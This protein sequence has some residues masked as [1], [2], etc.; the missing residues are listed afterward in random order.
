MLNPS[1]GEALPADYPAQDYGRMFDHTQAAGVG[2][3]GIR[4]LA[5][6]A[7]SGTAERHPIASP[8]PDPIGSAIATTPTCTR[9]AAD[10]A[11]AAGSCGQP[12]RG[13]DTF[14]DQHKAMGTILVGMATPEQF[15][16]SLAAVNK[17]PLSRGS[18]NSLA[19]VQRG[20]AGE[21]RE[22]FTASTPARRAGPAA[23]GRGVRVCQRR[24]RPIG[25]FSISGTT[26]SAT[27]T[28]PGSARI[29]G[30]LRVEARP[31]R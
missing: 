25:E 20:F 17:G 19:T 23:L 1:A 22:R 14:R 31:V 16:Q 21:T 28:G 7:L 15:E 26:F 13:G 3:V 29:S 27:K 18:L 6:G 5:G 8:P 10:A 4:V 12:G 11:G 2:V 9:A 30:K 24:R